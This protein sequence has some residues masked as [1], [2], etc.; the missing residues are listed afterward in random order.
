MYNRMIMLE[1][2]RKHKRGGKTFF[3]IFLQKGWWLT[4]LGV[5]FIYLSWLMFFG[6]F[7]GPVE[8][9]L[10]SHPSWYIDVSMLSEWALLL[11][12]FLFFIAFLRANVHYRNYKFMLDEYAVHLYQGLFFI[13]QTTIP[14]E[15]ITNVHIAQPYH[16]RLSGI[17]KLDI[18]TAA[19]KDSDKSDKR[20]NK[21]LM[22]M[23]DSSIAKALSRQILECAS[24]S[25]KGKHVYDQEELDEEDEEE[26]SEDD[27]D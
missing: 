15:Q 26:D 10:A 8:N 3:Y 18:V 24:R 27:D 19:D 14:Y 23:I 7:I 22:P 16:Y 11:G 21:F 13:R 2:E 9:F 5:G 12:L 1:F 4:L 6:P 20:T 17:A 25:R